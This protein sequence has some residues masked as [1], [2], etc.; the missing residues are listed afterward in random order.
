MSDST[1]VY[2]TR[3]PIP[4]GLGI[5]VHLGLF[6][7][8]FKAGAGVDFRLL[9]ASQDKALLKTH[10]SHR[11][12]NLIR[13]GGNIPALWTRARGA[14]TRVIGLSFVRGPQA[15]LSLPESGIT[16]PEHLRGKRLLLQRNHSAEIDFQYA[17]SR[18]TYEAALRSAGLTLDDVT[19]VEPDLTPAT[20][21]NRSSIGRI[22]RAWY[23]DGLI[24]LI[25][26]EVDVITSRTIG[27]PAPQLEFLFGLNRVFDL[28]DL[29]DE[30][31]R[32]NNSTPLTLTVDA[33]F[34]DQHR[35]ILVRILRRILQ[36]ER[37]ARDHHQDAVRFIAREQAVSEQIVEAAFGERLYD[38]IA[39]DFN[40][41]SIAALRDQKDY[42]LNLGLIGHDVDIDGWIDTS[43][44]EEARTAF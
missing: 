44:L 28:A 42:L 29:P 18:R 16:R 15:V 25:R 31:Q 6:Q 26:G 40:A 27:S 20:A 41:T 3:C 7:E 21:S 13:H 4:T 9:Q 14:D 33:G 12:N 1:T 11:L 32:A 43:L 30:V 19:L 5:G 2:Y 34:I 36:A 10:F 35:D 17:T 39:L 38:S 24:P 23:T 8:E 22:Q 37:W